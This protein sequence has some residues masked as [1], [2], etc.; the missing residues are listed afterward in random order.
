MDQHIVDDSDLQRENTQWIRSEWIG[1]NRTFRD[2]PD[3][4]AIEA[5][6][7]IQIPP[8]FEATLPSEHDS[9]S[10]MYATSNLP[11]WDPAVDT[12]AEDVSTG[13]IDFDAA[14]PSF[15]PS[16]TPLLP[17]RTIQRLHDA[18][19]QAWFDAKLSIRDARD[20]HDVRYYPLWYL[21]YARRVRLAARGFYRWSSVFGWL[22]EERADQEPEEEEWRQRTTDILSSLPG[23]TG[24]VGGKLYDLT[25][26]AL[27]ELLG[28]NPLAGAVLDAL[29]Q[30]IQERVILQEGELT[31]VLLA[32]TSFP[33]FI[34][35]GAVAQSNH[36]G[37]PAV[38]KY[39][40]LL[41]SH[42]PPRTFAFPLH[43]PPHHW[44]ACSVDIP[45]GRIRFGDGFHMDAPSSLASRLAQWL[46][47]AAG[48]SKVRIT[49]DL[50]C[51]S[52]HDVVSCGIIAVN[53]IAHQI[54]GDRLWDITCARTHRLQ[55]FCRIAKIIIRDSNKVSDTPP[56][57]DLLSAGPSFLKRPREHEQEEGEDM[58]AAKRKKGPAPSRAST[59]QKKPA[60]ASSKACL[61]KNRGENSADKP[62]ITGTG[63]SKKPVI[64]RNVQLEI[65]DSLHQGGQSNS[66][67]HDRVVAILIRHGLYRGDKRRLKK[68]EEA[69]KRDG[70]DPN[71][72][73][74]INN[75]NKS[76]K[77]TCR[78]PDV[79]N[80]SISSF[81]KSQPA[82]NTSTPASKPRAKPV[83]LTKFCPGLTGAIHPRIDYYIENCPS[84][85]AGAH[86]INF[87]VKR[88]YEVDRG[89]V[90]I[91]DSELSDEERAKAYQQQQLDRAWRIETS[92]QHS[93][94]VATN[95]VVQFT[96]RSQRELDDLTLVCTPCETVYSSRE[97]RNAINHNR[98]KT[99]AQMQCTPKIYSNPIRARLM[100]RYHGL[101][102]FLGKRSE[103]NVFHRF[104]L[105]VGEGQ[106]KNNQ[107][108]LGLVESTQLGLERNEWCAL[109]HSLSPR[110]YRNMAQ[111]IRVESEQSI[112]HRTSQRP[113]F[114]IGITDAS[115]EHLATYLKTY[116][117]PA[118]YPLCVSVDDTKLLPAMHPLYDG[119]EKS[120]YLIG[121]PGEKQLKVRSSEELERLMDQKH[122][123]ATKLRLWAISIPPRN[124]VVHHVA[125]MSGLVERNY[126][127]I[128]NVADGAAV[129]RDC[130][131][132]VAA[133]SQTISHTI[134]PPSHFTEPAI[135]VP[136]YNFR[137]TSSLIPKTRLM[138]G[139]LVGTTIFSGAR[140]LVLGDF[141]VY[142]KQ[143]LDLATTVDD[144]P[145]YD[146]D[147]IKAD[148]Q[149][150]NAAIRVFSAAS[151]KK[152][153]GD[154][155]KNMGLIVFLFVIGELVDAYESRTMT[156][157]TRAKVAIRARLFF[158]TWKVFLDKQGYPQARYYISSAADKIY[159]MLIDGL[160]GLILIHRD[161]L[162]P[163]SIP[164]LPWKHVSMGNE[165]IFAALRDLFPDMT[166]AQAIFAI[167]NLRATMS[168]A[169]QA[170]FSAASFKKTANGYSFA[171]VTDDR[172][173]N[174]VELAS[175]PTDAELTT[176]YGEAIEENTVLWSLLNINFHALAK[177][178]PVIVA[179]SPVDTDDHPE[180]HLTEDDIADTEASIVDL[181]IK[182]E[183]EQALAAVQ[184]VIGLR[185][186]EEEEVDLCAYAAAALVVDNLSRIDNLPELED[187]A[188]L[189]ICRK[190]IAQIIKMTPQTVE[191]LL[192][193]LKT[194]FGG[195]SQRS[196]DK[197]AL[198]PPVISDITASELQPLVVIREMH[199]TEH[200]RKGV[201]SYKAGSVHDSRSAQGSNGS[202]SKQPSE[203][204]LVARRIQSVIRN[205]N[206][207]KATTG[208]NRKARTE[209]PELE[210]MVPKSTGNAANAA[211]AAEVRA[212]TASRR[213]ARLL[214]NLKC[215][216]DVAEAGIG[217]LTPLRADDYLF[218][219]E[220]NDILLARVITIVDSIGRISYVFVQTFLHSAGRMFQRLHSATA[221]L[222][223]SRFAHLPAG[224]ILLR[225]P[226]QV[227]LKGNM[228][229]VMPATALTYKQLHSEQGNWFG[230]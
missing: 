76:F 44:M 225:I 82:N 113:R 118:N 156:H 203:K 209:Q 115:Y 147:V 220:R 128:S 66:A 90:S 72:G 112:K 92:P 152:L 52:Q 194:S 205:A 86:Q 39:A 11:S 125:A 120:W 134:R 154:V 31:P 13:A 173:L 73:L 200:A 83:E 163:S 26:E 101:E 17:L 79:R 40:Q 179:P 204:Q 30:E 184:D 1:C 80:T 69:C 211:A 215:H 145:L 53:A 94:V 56:L 123:P 157:A 119:P 23:W 16:G 14:A 222:G 193:G 153:S 171:D 186:A 144:P 7:A 59:V 19:G 170:L 192:I 20:A 129:E 87:Y 164:L 97:F 214:K 10:H 55:A 61:P 74:D 98:D 105:A 108:F 41:K 35:T 47:S 121:L 68:L 93:A 37:F 84:T 38:A 206:G 160:L 103:L 46:G 15:N 223:I 212:S 77:G 199:Q 191:S 25:F 159:D 96:V 180:A 91:T 29:I 34:E 226:D 188:Q 89:I 207:R 137:E 110:A 43:S 124:W 33:T 109:I 102:E 217:P 24:H 71:P 22:L 106:F 81:F 100:A 202:A 6:R 126:R 9:P 195:P 162:S 111:H 229:E 166:L 227:K 139:K 51:G 172:S 146:R 187:P 45:T 228:A 151:L 132:R 65:L 32:D 88:L 219:I 197:P 2:I 4:V 218:V 198:L 165:R 149:D 135:V 158:S 224:S 168:A 62:E 42:T 131:A 169:K 216:S 196:L 67:R 127:F 190:D 107:V 174:L 3:F 63:A 48:M 99:H 138:R 104:A 201:Q 177:A 182:D 18:F 8:E 181:S 5:V 167:P 58:P 230:W 36:L 130:Q 178:P 60:P 75:P 12:G 122:S 78:K 85:G 54:L 176:L 133:K 175:F 208:L 213:R 210:D 64:P 116:G 143:L 185:R 50:P 70:G 183:L 28:D 161:H 155:E 150:D 142:Y 136:L 49:N 95:C 189:E 221:S 148:K 57:L 141:T 140:G 27:A 114:P 117:Y 21:S